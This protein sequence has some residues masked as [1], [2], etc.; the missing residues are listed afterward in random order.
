MRSE[1][2]ILEKIRWYENTIKQ[3]K[4]NIEILRWILENESEIYKGE[5]NQ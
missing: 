3:C 1:Q 5:V 4:N 2:E